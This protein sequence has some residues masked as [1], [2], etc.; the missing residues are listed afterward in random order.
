MASNTP[1]VVVGVN[2]VGKVCFELIV[3]IVMVARWTVASLIVRFMRSTWPLV[4]GLKTL[5]GLT[6]YEYICK[7]WTS[8]PERFKLNPLQKMPGLNSLGAIAIGCAALCYRTY[9]SRDDLRT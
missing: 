3:P 4:Q 8:Q 7:C 1:S 2:E 9:V 6:P 5:K